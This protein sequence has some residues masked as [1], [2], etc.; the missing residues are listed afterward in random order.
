MVVNP[1]A[2][3][4]YPDAVRLGVL[5][6]LRVV[7]AAGQTWPVRSAKQRI[8]LAVLLLDAG[9]TISAERM[10]EALWDEA[11]PA[12][13][14]TVMRNYVMRLRRALGPAGT[15]IVRQ[16]PGWAIALHDDDEL[17]VA[18]VDRLRQAA[19]AALAAQSWRQASALLTEALSC[20]RGEPLIDVPSPVLVRREA[21]QLGEL[22]LQLTEAR[23]DADLHL[24]RHAELVPEL[25]GLAARHPFRERIRAQLML[26]CYRCG[27]QAAALDAYRDAHRTLTEELGVGPGPELRDMH[28]RILAGDRDLFAT[29]S[30]S[31]SAEA[32][33]VHD[34]DTAA[35]CRRGLP[36]D[37]TA[38]IGRDDEIEI[39]TAQQAGANAIRVISGMPGVGKTALA[40][41]A[42]HLLASAFGDRQL[43][44]DLHGHTPGRNPVSPAAAL[45]EL[46][47]ATGVDTSFLPADLPGRSAMWRDK[48]AGQRT[49]LVLDNA[50]SSAQV[51]PLLPGS[52][53]C[54]VLVTSRRQLADLPGAVV[55]VRLP[56]LTRKTSRA[57]F[58]AL[59]PRAVSEDRGLVDELTALAGHLPLA[60]SLLARVYACHPSWTLSNLITETRDSL[61]AMTAERASVSA[62]FSLS[63]RHLHPAQRRLLALLSMHPG[64]STDEHSAAALAGV[65]VSEARWQLDRLHNECLLTETGYRRYRMHDLI[66]SYATVKARSMVSDEETAAAVRRLLGYYIHAAHADGQSL[67]W[68]RAERASLLACLDYA[69]TAGWQPEVVALTTAIDRLLQRDGPW[70]LAV[71]L[72]GAAVQAARGLG[73]RPALAQCL[74]QLGAIRR[75]TGDHQ[76]A[77]EDL[78]A[79]LDLYGA[80]GDQRGE[81]ATLLELGHVRMLAGDFKAAGE[82][83]RQALG[84]CRATSDETGQARALTLTGTLQQRTA[85]LAGARSALTEAVVIYRDLDD[86]A[87]LALALRPLS[88]LYRLTSDYDT[89]TACLTEA[90]GLSRD[91]DDR[92]G[93]AYGLVGLG[94]IRWRTGD[95]QAAIRDLERAVKL[96]RDLGYRLGEAN[97][98]GLLGNVRQAAG[99][100]PAAVLDL[101]QALRLYRQLGMPAGEAST[102]AWLG[103][104]RVTT[105]DFGTAATELAEALSIS[106][107]LG[108]Q[109]GEATSLTRLAGLHHAKA[110]ITQARLLY[111]QALDLARQITSPWDEAHALTGLGHCARA[112]GDMR[113]AADLLENAR[114]IFQKIGAAEAT[115]VAADLK[116]LPVQGAGADQGP[117]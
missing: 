95:Y 60:I 23:V 99:D 77:A 35:G 80:L 43:F 2:I 111:Q 6:P 31:A 74:L 5:G 11:A 26:A 83:A 12:N 51:A 3:A 28:Q 44:I 97:A 86:K 81:S 40:V 109:G 98:L 1:V 10:A 19:R 45:A 108:D 103:N 50:A 32:V 117:D 48:L 104:V 58:V 33:T 107:R 76:E 62:A 36:L 63:W 17:D 72:H 64:T 39:I 70:P 68:A 113:A 90:I 42:A 69:T 21:G 27:N 73:N 106:R 41:H 15:R 8:M 24:G 54:L 92:L 115:Q 53:D 84:I 75:L 94:G 14:P 66:R 29:T 89:A 20:W 116:L 47:T 37:T 82:S 38:L 65:P 102:L 85:D 71:R 93:Q 18:A 96:H 87:G 105:G 57:M 25:R 49:L 22:R 7:D 91:L 56:T 114:R 52:G 110:E 9:T 78:A 100:Y 79:A 55:P 112:D 101:E 34:R 4:G 67:T 30:A 16:P 46:I 88:N 61:L 59:T 13:A